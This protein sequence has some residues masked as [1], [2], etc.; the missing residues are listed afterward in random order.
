MQSNAHFADADTA[1]M[2]AKF[3]LTF[4]RDTIWAYRI[5]T[6]ELQDI[7]SSYPLSS[8]TSITKLTL[9]TR[10]HLFSYDFSLVGR[11]RSEDL[12]LMLQKSPQWT[13]LLARNSVGS[14]KGYCMYSVEANSSSCNVTPLYADDDSVATTLFGEVLTVLLS[15]IRHIRLR[16][17]Q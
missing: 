14:V 10:L 8:E 6:K 7:L 12:C 2:Y 11:D 17:P 9:S 15:N 3:A 1:K 16:L 13:T 5:G 4:T